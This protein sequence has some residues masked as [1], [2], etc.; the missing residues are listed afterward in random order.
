MKNIILNFM[1]LATL[2]LP[3]FAHQGGNGGDDMELKLK[4][5]PLQI[6]ELL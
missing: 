4:T 6:A 3:A 5:R 1:T 2:S